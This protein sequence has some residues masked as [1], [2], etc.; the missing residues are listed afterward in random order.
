M[1]RKAE[2]EADSGVLSA[3]TTTQRGAA[4]AR[5]T[6]DVFPVVST[7]GHLHELFGRWQHTRRTRA[8]QHRH[9]LESAQQRSGADGE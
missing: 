6:L 5:Q 8:T 2:E 7:S 3:T 4:W 9:R 1:H